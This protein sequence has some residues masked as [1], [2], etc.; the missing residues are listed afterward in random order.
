MY[1]IIYVIFLANAELARPISKIRVRNDQIFQNSCAESSKVCVR[2]HHDNYFLINVACRSD[3][4][5]ITW[6][7]ATIFANFEHLV[8]LFRYN[9]LGACQELSRNSD[10]KVERISR[11]LPRELERQLIP[12]GEPDAWDEHNMGTAGPMITNY[13]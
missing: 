4:N 11:L 7:H 3:A 13:L 9:L 6:L 8:S 1:A 2:N 12:N 5:L 10:I